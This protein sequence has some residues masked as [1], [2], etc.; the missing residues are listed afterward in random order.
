MPIDEPI[1][2]YFIATR[3]HGFVG[4]AVV[5]W[6]SDSKGYTTNLND[7]GEYDE[8]S[9]RAIVEPAPPG[10]CRMLPV[11]EVWKLSRPYF[12]GQDMWP[13][14]DGWD[15]PCAAEGTD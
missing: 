2:R 4:N 10:E 11:D 1:K 8:A 9:A 15:T 3:K 13:H 12:D 14:F 6:C 5:F 7:A